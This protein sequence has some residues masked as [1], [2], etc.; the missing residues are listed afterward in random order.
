M[1]ESFRVLRETGLHERFF[2]DALYK[3]EEPFVTLTECK[4]LSRIHFNSMVLGGFDP[5]HTALSLLPTCSHVTSLI[6]WVGYQW[7]DDD[8]ISLM[9]KYAADTTVLRHLHVGIDDFQSPDTVARI[10]RALVQALSSNESVRKLFLVGFYLDDTESQMLVDKLQA[11]RTL[12]ELSLCEE[13]CKSLAPVIQ[14]LSPRVSSNYTLLAVGGAQGRG[15]AR[16]T[17]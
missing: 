13:E 9:A 7:F 6:L 2:L 1:A 16:R 10:G 12:Y 8:A 11:S 4:K 5:V 15:A 3:V 14:K 17:A